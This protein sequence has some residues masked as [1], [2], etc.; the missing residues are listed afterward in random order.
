[1]LGIP[2]LR[3]NR[4]ATRLAL[5]D[6]S[7]DM[8]RFLRPLRAEVPLG[9]RIRPNQAEDVQ[10][11]SDISCRLG[12]TSSGQWLS[13]H[14]PC[15]QAHAAES[16]GSVDQ[17][18]RSLDCHVR[19]AAQTQGQPPAVVCSG[20][21]LLTTAVITVGTVMA[22][23]PGH[24]PV[25]A[26]AFISPIIHRALRPK[27]EQG[28]YPSLFGRETPEAWSR[29]RGTAFHTRAH[30]LRPFCH[31]HVASPDAAEH[32]EVRRTLTQPEPVLPSFALIC[33]YLL[34]M[35]PSSTRQG[36]LSPLGFHG[37][38][39]RL[40]TEVGEMPVKHFDANEYP[41]IPLDRAI[42]KTT[43]LVEVCGS[44]KV[45]RQHIA[46][47]LGHKNRSGALS[48]TLASLISYG[49]VRRWRDAEFVDFFVTPLALKVTAKHDDD[50]PDS[51]ASA[52]K[53][54]PVF[55]LLDDHFSHRVASVPLDEVEGFLRL[56][57]DIPKSG[58]RACATSFVN[59][60]RFLDRQQER[61]APNPSG[62][63]SS[64]SAPP[65]ISNKSA[66]ASDEQRSAKP[67]PVRSTQGIEGNSG[68]AETPQKL[69]E[70]FRYSC[71]GTTV[72]VLSNNPVS[73]KWLRRLEQLV[74]V[75]AQ[76]LDEADEPPNRP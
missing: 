41:S 40:M 33:P 1:M 2:A 9:W 12:R 46:E 26:P 75:H 76:F 68:T 61:R 58:V 25:G 10:R 14:H 8:P 69:D 44:R 22:M 71:D 30:L 51:L 67:S 15:L 70:W 11:F 52:A 57:T 19:G 29:F 6:V 48:R 42:D 37:F 56:A 31:Q 47:A 16:H 20:S 32:W 36:I 43:R 21:S 39:G 72:L 18:P 49:L 34:P 5:R 74:A 60:R 13:E 62:L 35:L 50:H 23:H 24:M 7:E 64:G 53:H 59:T 38:G 66:N 73:S 45:D 28:C 17:T 63:K 55:Q 3:V 54:P 27:A 65:R 4:Q